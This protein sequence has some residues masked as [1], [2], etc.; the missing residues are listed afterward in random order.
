MHYSSDSA[1]YGSLDRFS[2]ES[3]NLNNKI[4]CLAKLLVSVEFLFDDLNTM[5]TLEFTELVSH[6]K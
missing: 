6:S 3:C 4:V 2:R 1:S 5:C